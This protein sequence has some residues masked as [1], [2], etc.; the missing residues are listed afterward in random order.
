MR[1]LIFLILLFPNIGVASCPSWT[2]DFKFQLEDADVPQTMVW[3]SGWA[4][5][6]QA[7]QSKTN[8]CLSKCG[9]LDSKRLSQIL[10]QF[11]AGERIS[12]EVAAETL[13]KNLDTEFLCK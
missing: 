2:P 5:S 9:Y 13:E 1:K 12:A 7:T 4:F 10:N 6:L 8:Y 11:H 3:L